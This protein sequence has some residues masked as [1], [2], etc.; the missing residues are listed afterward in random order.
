MLE[1]SKKLPQFEGA[2]WLAADD[3]I[4]TVCQS[5]PFSPR[6]SS[7]PTEYLTLSLLH[8]LLVVLADTRADF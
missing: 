3:E 6:P 1:S 2:G 4:C 8:H 7:L 5:T